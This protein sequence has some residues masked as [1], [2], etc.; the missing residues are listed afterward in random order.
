M[1]VVA[2]PVDNY[3]DLTPEQIEQYREHARSDIARAKG[4]IETMATGLR[5]FS[6]FAPG[7]AE[8]EKIATMCQMI[9][10]FADS[11]G[12]LLLAATAIVRVAE[13]DDSPLVDLG[14]NG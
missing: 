4:W 6:F 8:E 14:P 7:T 12:H 3:D 2:H 9:D 1:R 5:Q 11:S 10:Q 13:L